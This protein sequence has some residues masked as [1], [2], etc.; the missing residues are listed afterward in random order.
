MGIFGEFQRAYAA[1]GVATFP[2]IIEQGEKR[3]AIKHYSKIGMRGSEQLALRF[4]DHDALGFMCGQR[5]GVTVLDV[6][7]TDKSVL[8]DALTRHGDTPLVVRSGSG[9]WQA[10]FRHNGERRMIRPWADRP[11]D[12]LGGGY[13][14]AP[15][16][17]GARGHYEII[18]GSLDDLE[19]LPCIRGLPRAAEKPP[20]TGAEW[21]T[22]TRGE[23]NK[24]MWRFCMT[25]AHGVAGFDELLALA[26]DAN[27]GFAP[28]LGDAEVV[29]TARSAWHYQTSGLNRF[30]GVAHIQVGIDEV[31]TLIGDRYAF[32]LLC[33]LRRHHSSAPTFVISAKPVAKIFGWK[34]EQIRGARAR[35]EAQGIIRCINPGGKRKG[36][37]SVWVWGPQGDDNNN[38][39]PRSF[40]PPLLQ[41]LGRS[42]LRQDRAPQVHHQDKT[43]PPSPLIGGG[44]DERL[45]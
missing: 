39:T 16:S 37:C 7:A 30:G 2:V 43:Y 15:P 6:D 19:R 3:P 21:S 45:V 33:L 24:T 13:V 35:L 14:V 12:V 34:P 32:P 44:R 11:I 18:R 28:P 40:L 26:M 9:N 31:D 8:A 36:D 41:L 10:W 5:S 29:K 4:G 42:P 1:R 20:R 23:R 38:N 25:T 17:R 27:R 22:A